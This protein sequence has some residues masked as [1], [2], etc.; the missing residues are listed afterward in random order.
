VSGPLCTATQTTASTFHC[1]PGTVSRSATSTWGI[2]RYHSAWRLVA[3]QLPPPW[4]MLC[5]LHTDRFLPGSLCI[6]ARPGPRAPPPL[7]DDGTTRPLGQHHRTP[8]TSL[9]SDVPLF[10]VLCF[11]ATTLCTSRRPHTPHQPRFRISNHRAVPRPTGCTNALHA[12]LARSLARCY[13]SLSFAAHCAHK[14]WMLKW[15]VARADCKTADTVPE[16]LMLQ[17]MAYKLS[18]SIGNNIDRITTAAHIPP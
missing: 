4:L 10:C 5:V 2:S 7:F 6:E 1:Q 3:Q 13:S 11:A 18:L 16:E 17:A 12:V 15:L 9:Y 14:Q 8:M